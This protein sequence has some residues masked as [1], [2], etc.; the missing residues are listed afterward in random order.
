MNHSIPFYFLLALAALVATV[1]FLMTFFVVPEDWIKAVVLVTVAFLLASLAVPLATL[2][3]NPSG[4]VA[5]F[6]EINKP[7]PLTFEVI[8]DHISRVALWAVLLIASGGILKQAVK[9]GAIN[10]GWFGLGVTALVVLYIAILVLN[11]IVFLWR[12]VTLKE[13]VSNKQKALFSVG[14]GVVFLGICSLSTHFALAS[15]KGYVEYL[16]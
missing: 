8:T 12:A 14:Y 6:F 1:A 11:G 3:E 4:A 15:L 2:L 10:A 16:G 5:S 9:E 13:G 7:L